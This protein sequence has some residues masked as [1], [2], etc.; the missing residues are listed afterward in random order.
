MEN[1]IRDI[2]FFPG[3]S[4]VTSAKEN[5]RSLQ[6]FCLR[7]GYNL[8]EIT[9]WNCCGSSSAHS[10]N[11]RLAFDLSARNIAHMTSKSSVLIACPNCYKR[12]KQTFLHLREDPSTRSRFEEMWQTPFNR[13]LHLMPFL[14]FLAEQDVSNLL[15]ENSIALQGMSFVP[16][17]GC[18]LAR[19]PIM[20]NE[21]SF[22]GLMENI[23]TNLGAK[24]LQ[25]R[26]S[27]QCCG[28]FLSISRPEIITPIVNSIMQGA[29]DSG[30]EC[31]VTAC[32]MCHLNLEVRCTLKHKIPIFH[33]SELL[34]ISMEEID[35]IDW[36]KRHLIDPRP[37][38]D[39]YNIL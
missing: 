7:L 6:A 34:A 16:Y 28:T 35:H 3:C 21:P 15:A 31:I 30:A 27:S 32:S 36:F 8:V 38:L 5:Y 25:W 12:L 14:E 9:D 26:Y 18:M 10:M 22:N 1:L 39:S 23:L 2:P 4:L 17:Y 37:L 11:L 19:P 24:P 29:I 13:D 20:R 33:F